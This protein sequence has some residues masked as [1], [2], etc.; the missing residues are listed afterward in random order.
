M[1]FKHILL[2][3]DFSEGAAPATD[4][5]V[6]LAL[7][8]GARITLFHAYSYPVV[9]YAEGIPFPI[10]E[11]EAAARSELG[12]ELEQLQRRWAA[13]DSLLGCGAPWQ[14]ILEAVK[15]CG[16]DVVVMGTHGRR[17]FARAVLGSVAEKVVRLAPVPVLTVPRARDVDALAAE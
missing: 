9:T 10:A 17:G 6:D 16:A 7:R 1:A 13:S 15:A 2:A 11:L 4:A 14:Q 12:A 8:T 5:A 3:T